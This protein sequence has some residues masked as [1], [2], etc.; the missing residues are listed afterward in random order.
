LENHVVPKHRADE[1]QR[2]VIGRSRRQREPVTSRGQQ[3]HAGK[4]K[5]TGIFGSHELIGKLSLQIT[6]FFRS[7][8]HANR[9]I[10]HSATNAYAV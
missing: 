8:V 4:N 7:I 6:Q 9:N 5:N 3:R 10:V 2:R 1:W